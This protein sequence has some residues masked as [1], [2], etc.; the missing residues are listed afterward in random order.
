MP[1]A[2]VTGRTWDDRARC[3]SEE[4]LGFFNVVTV[5]VTNGAPSDQSVRTP[6]KPAVRIF[7]GVMF[8]IILAGLLS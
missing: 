8:I 7:A 1:E 5:I 6:K 2:T 3:C 4:S